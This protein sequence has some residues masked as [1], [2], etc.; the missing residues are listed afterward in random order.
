VQTTLL[1]V[2]I[3]II[4]ALVAALVGPYFIDWGRFRPQLEVEASRLVGMPVRVAGKIDA[5]LLPTPSVMLGEVAVGKSGQESQLEARQLA[6]EFA[7]GPLLRGQWRASQLKLV[8]PAIHLVV[9]AD[10]S[11]ASTASPLGLVPDQLAAEHFLIEDGRIVLHGAGSPQPQILDR[12][13]FVG[14]IGSLKG[15]L[16]GAGSFA[17]D[18]AA[19]RYSIA[20]GR[21]TETEDAKLH[22]ELQSYQG[23]W[24]AIADGQL[25]FTNV[26]EFVG[27]LSASHSA[28]ADAAGRGLP[29]RGTSHLTLSAAGAF[30]DNAELAYGPEDRAVR[31]SAAARIR[32]G[33]DARYDAVVSGRQLDLDAALGGAAAGER[34]A[35][36]TA[37]ELAGK[38]A[39]PAVSIPGRVGIAV[40]VL[41]VGGS[42]VHDLHADLASDAGGWSIE[43]LEL[44][45]PGSTDF[46]ASGRIEPGSNAAR[47]TGPASIESGDPEIF[48]AWIA[49]RGLFSERSG[50]LRLTGDLELGADR[51]A[52]ER[53]RAAMAGKAFQG[54]FAYAAARGTHPARVETE[55]RAAELDLDPLVSF[56]PRFVSRLHTSPELLVSAAVD[57]LVLGGTRGRKA[58]VDLR[59]A[60]GDLTIKRLSIADLGGAGIEA[61]GRLESLLLAP[62]GNL[63]LE[64]KAARLEGLA[65]AAG[66]T[67]RIGG[68][69]R[70]LVGELSS[71]DARATLA[72]D[73]GSHA[74]F[75]ME[76][77]TGPLRFKLTSEGTG[78]LLDPKTVQVHTAG[79]AAADDGRQLVSLMG[80]GHSFN[81]D[82]APAKLTFTAN[83]TPA[84][85]LTFEG[86]LA[87]AGLTMR[88]TGAAR[89]LDPDGPSAGID[90]S[91]AALDASPAW[92]DRG[93]PLPVKLQTKLTLAPGR[94]DL[95]D[96][97]GSFSRSAIRGQ[98]GITFGERSRIEG[99]LDA[100]E[101]FVPELLADAVGLPNRSGTLDA[102]LMPQAFEK[103]AFGVGPARIEFTAQR[104]VLG[105]GLTA[106]DVHSLVRLQPNEIAFDDIEAELAGGRIEGE[107]TFRRDGAGAAAHARI[108]LADVDGSV[109][110][111]AS[112]G[113][114]P[115]QG[116]L[117]LQAEVDGAGSSPAAL[118]GSIKGAA[119]LSLKGA[120]LAGMNPGTFRQVTDAVDHGLEI[121]PGKVAELARSSLARGELRVPHC[122]G[123]VTILNGR[124]R[125][126]N[127]TLKG[128]G[129]D[130]TLTGAADLTTKTVDLGLTLAG[131]PGDGA[132]GTDRPE[133]A[134]LLKGPIA[135][136]QPTV[137]SSAFAIWLT[138]RSLDRET[139]RIE[140]GQPGLESPPPPV[141]VRPGPRA[142]ASRPS[143]RAEKSGEQSGALAA[144]M[145]LHPV[146]PAKPATPRP[147]GPRLAVRDGAVPAPAPA[148]SRTILERLFGSQP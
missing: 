24:T 68:V 104:A 89:L 10:G 11:V 61:R 103:A 121:Q 65:A 14:E 27:T 73:R 130:V 30:L 48:A 90:L 102:W 63:S 128:E 52:I 141:P 88:A 106:R 78:N 57:E 126:A 25:R 101:I 113:R 120:R 26:P 55:L 49:G 43:K 145:Q 41:S 85:D 80:L 125:V 79:T 20:A 107:L 127:L 7:L 129:A 75:A 36:V 81:L 117:S 9:G 134:I 147:A 15:P 82:K 3:A 29:W 6:V 12:L 2:S 111:G 91:I 28:G 40:D 118:V 56:V 34:Q 83:G 76:G 60:A 71:L 119:T 93:K 5:R 13:S 123:A 148:R 35:F 67:P 124:A 62:H 70:E 131:P 33:P 8:G 132:P 18:A 144:P 108:A 140:T 99:H 38:L 50:P 23:R 105:S 137:D 42:Q 66:L 46:R 136:V 45:A 98:F 122:D 19:Y 21:L 110:M 31:L 94:I 86:G 4:L 44:R 72:I 87:A 135:T 146:A 138:L 47:F 96:L 112:T 54:R 77:T 53:L 114:H 16:R 95:K 64:L 51:I 116:L 32:F 1:G 92:G 84:N 69:A 39:P 100:E 17:T 109:L 74:T 115:I 59:Y 58:Q 22:L 97:T 37:R 133:L 143:G 139:R 142:P